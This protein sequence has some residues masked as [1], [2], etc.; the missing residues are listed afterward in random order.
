MELRD[1]MEETTPMGESFPP[2]FGNGGN[3]DINDGDRVIIRKMPEPFHYSALPVNVESRTRLFEMA[4]Y[5]D[6]AS[7]DIASEWS[8]EAIVKMRE[9]TYQ[10]WR[11]KMSPADLTRLLECC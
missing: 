11:I 3:G 5:C 4:W 9:P 6:P 2:L 7:W 8:Y 10:G 1:Y